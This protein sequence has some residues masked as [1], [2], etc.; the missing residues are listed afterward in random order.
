MPA[1]D[2]EFVLENR[3]AEGRVSAR[4]MDPPDWIPGQL[5]KRLFGAS[6]QEGW[7]SPV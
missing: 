1:K 5:P 7:L 2:S 4:P 6:I 3:P